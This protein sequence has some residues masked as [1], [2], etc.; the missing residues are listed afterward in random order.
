MR[1]QTALKLLH[2]YRFL[3]KEEPDVLRFD[4]T[5]PRAAATAP[6]WQSLDLLRRAKENRLLDETDYRRFKEE[7]F[8]EGR[9][10]GAVKRDLTQL[11]KERREEDPE[12][13]RRKRKM[14]TVKRFLSTLKSLKRDMELLKLVPSDIVKETE[15]LIRKLEAEIG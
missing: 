14:A 13:V 8:E 7:L 4:E 11:I 15:S 12:E 3:E 5:A 10:P 9:D 6:T 2:S 1:K